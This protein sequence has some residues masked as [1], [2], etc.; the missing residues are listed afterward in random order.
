MFCFRDFY[1]LWYPVRFFAHQCLYQGLGLPLWNPYAFGGV[2]TVADMSLYPPSV[3]TYL[4]NFNLGLKW[5]IVSHYLAAACGMYLL[6]RELKTSRSGAFLSA[7]SFV[8]GGYM[9]G[10]LDMLNTLTSASLMPFVFLFFSIYLIKNSFPN[11]AASGGMMALFVLSGDITVVYGL[12]CVL[13]CYSIHQCFVH[14]NVSPLKRFLLVILIGC[15]LSLFKIIPTIEAIINSSRAAQ[16]IAFKNATLWSFSPLQ[17]LEFIVPF[18]ADILEPTKFQ[19]EQVWLSCPYFGLLPF[20]FLC[21]AVVNRRQQRYSFF[22]FTFLI[23][24]ILSFGSILPLYYWC[25]KILPGFSL[26]RFPVKFLCLVAFSGSLLSGFGLDMVLTS[27]KL[28]RFLKYSFPILLVIF[29]IICIVGSNYFEPI[30]KTLFPNIKGEDNNILFLRFYH[31]ICNLM[32]SSMFLGI[33]ILS[34]WSIKTKTLLLPVLFC[35]IISDLFLA[36]CKYQPTMQEKYFFHYT[37]TVGF[38]NN[39]KEIFR[40]MHTPEAKKHFAGIEFNKN[41]VLNYTEYQRGIVPYLGLSHRIFYAH[42]TGYMA[43]C[44]GEYVDLLTL[45]MNYPPTF[46][47]LRELINLF[48]IKYIISVEKLIPEFVQ[49]NWKLVYD[50]GIYIYKNESVFPRAFFVP[51]A[52]SVAPGKVFETV[53]MMNFDPRNQV[54]LGTEKAQRHKDTV[55]PSP[56]PSPI[57]REREAQRGQEAGGKRQV[58]NP[59]VKITD[60]SLH[61]VSIQ[62]DTDRDGWIVLTDNYY[63]GWKAYVNNHE[64][65]IYRADYAFRAIRIKSGTNKIDFVYDPLS[66]KAG[67]WGS[68]ISLIFIAGIG[69]LQ[70]KGRSGILA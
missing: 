56:R 53:G 58:H 42:V 5:F 64:T 37:K 49:N 27:K 59:V 66:L 25:Y 9:L 29:I 6:S 14:K 54:V 19:S 43:L 31:I 32:T 57:R 46:D 41:F 38:I 40:V 23:F 48:N 18:F 22:T 63:P 47:V 10:I 2:P 69:L 7:I 50:E 28:L 13:L 55:E 61:K 39:D 20:I 52:I 4:P 8:F 70:L 67:I 1:R 3:L 11:L 35:I 60:Y 15:G 12:N 16:G 68:I 45:F 44:P 30:L 17:M 51:K 26:F 33:I 34:L 21:L 24:L 36:G 62:A 65:K